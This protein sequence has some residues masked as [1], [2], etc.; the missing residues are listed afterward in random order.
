LLVFYT[1]ANTEKFDEEDPRYTLHGVWR[2]LP[3][4]SEATA[5]LRIHKDRIE[6]ADWA[7]YGARLNKVVRRLAFTVSAPMTPPVLSVVFIVMIPL[8]PRD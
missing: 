2:T 7:A 5:E 3:R 1:S 6:P 4:R 8:P